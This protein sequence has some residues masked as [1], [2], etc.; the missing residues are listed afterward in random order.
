MNAR[1]CTGR[2]KV[3]ATRNEPTLTDMMPAAPVRIAVGIVVPH[4]PIAVGLESPDTEGAPRRIADHQVR[5][6]TPLDR[7][8]P[9]FPAA[10]YFEDQGIAAIDVVEALES[11]GDLIKQGC[12]LG[13]GLDDA[14]PV[15]GP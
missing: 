9:D 14:R 5:Q 13:S 2:R 6:G 11:R 3:G 15:R 4:D 8:R 12:E 10:M 7:L 1:L